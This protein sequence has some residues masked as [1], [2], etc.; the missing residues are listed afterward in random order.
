MGF[1]LV[2]YDQ[3]GT[4]ELKEFINGMASF[5]ANVS[6]L[7]MHILRLQSDVFHDVNVVE[8]TVDERLDKVIASAETAKNHFLTGIQEFEGILSGVEMRHNFQ[9]EK[10]E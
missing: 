5:T 7:P 8:R 10:M 6:D 2:D 4:I 9:I 1:H 3:G